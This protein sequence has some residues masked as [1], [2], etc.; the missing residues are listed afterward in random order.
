MSVYTALADAQHRGMSAQR[1]LGDGVLRGLGA[2]DRPWH[3]AAP[4]C[5]STYC[6]V[7]QLGSF[8]LAMG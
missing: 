2:G 7:S 1:R 8:S 6:G 4:G 5:S 3:D